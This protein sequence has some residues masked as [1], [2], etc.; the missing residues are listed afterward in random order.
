MS[1]YDFV[2]NYNT[3]SDG[4]PLVCVVFLCNVLDQLVASG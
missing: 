3:V 1:Y 4:R 2:N